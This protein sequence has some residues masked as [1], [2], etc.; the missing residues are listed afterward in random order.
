MAAR[1][2]HRENYDAVMAIVK[3]RSGAY[4]RGVD[5][6]YTMV[7][8]A[9]DEQSAGCVS[10]RSRLVRGLRPPSRAGQCACTPMSRCASGCEVNNDQCA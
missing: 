6:T 10:L 8:K 4:G 2:G 7:H 9:K 1:L 3:E 5:Y